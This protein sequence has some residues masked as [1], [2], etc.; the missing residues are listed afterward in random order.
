M[1]YCPCCMLVYQNYIKCNTHIK[2]KHNDLHTQLGI[3]DIK[4]V[5]HLTFKSDTFIPCECTIRRI[6]INGK[7][8]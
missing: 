2:A 7:S 5:H 3:K 6:K 4:P 8:K 1:H